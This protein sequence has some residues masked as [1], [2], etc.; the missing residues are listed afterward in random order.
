VALRV[1]H[2]RTLGAYG[3]PHGHPFGPDRLEAFWRELVRRGLESRVERAEPVRAARADLLRFHT[4]EYVTLVEQRSHEGVGYLDYGDTPVFPGVYEAAATVAGSTL[5]AARWML[6]GE[7][8]R[9]FVPIGGLHHARREG[10]AGF[11]VFNDIGVVIEW[12]RAEHNMR[13]IAYVDIDAHHGDGVF[14]SFEDDPELIFADI[15]EDG[16]YLYPG[17]GDAAETG[18]GAA[19]G[20]KLN[21]PLEP[22]AGDSVFLAHWPRVE[23]FVRA[24]RPRFIILQAGADSIAGDP[25][26]HLALSPAGHAHAARRL[27]ALADELC[28]GHVLALGGGGYNRDNLAV[29]WCEVVQAMLDEGP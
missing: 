3:F 23:A 15:H 22:G 8:R 21:I 6:A 9:A 20:T 10:A 4:E 18:R 1:Y 25:L 24:A 26:T 14:Y 27:T 2:G 29:T 28:A 12:L 19:K 7:G 5:D 16:R 13:R 17:T 11:C